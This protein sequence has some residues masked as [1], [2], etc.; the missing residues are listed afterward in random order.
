MKNI[1][2]QTYLEHFYKEDLSAFLQAK[3]EP[4]AIRINTL[5]SSPAQMAG[6]LKQWKVD[7][8]FTPF[9]KNGI[10][11]HEDSLPLSHTL[12][13]FKG[14]FQYQGL[15]SQIPALALNPL[16]GQRVLDMAAAPGSKS[17]QLAAL[18]ENKGLL[19]L[20]DAVRSRLQALNSN[21]QKAGAINQLITYLPAERFGN[22]FPNFFDKILLDA[23]CT[24]LGTLCNSAEV[25]SWWSLQKLDKLSSL[26]Q[27]LLISAYK[28]LKPG[29]ELVYSTCSIA[30]EENEMAVQ[31]L[32]D[33]YHLK[34]LPIDNIPGI[35]FLPGISRYGSRKLHPD[36]NLT[37]RVAP[38]IHNMEG[39]F[40][41]R[42]QKTEE[43]KTSGLI[44]GATLRE[45]L[46][47]DDAAVSSSL[48]SI[49]DYWEIEQKIWQDYRFI[50]TKNRIWIV[51]KFIESLPEEGFTSAGLLL[52]EKKLNSWKL[53]NQSVQF[54]GNRIQQRRISLDV[55]D[56]KKLFAEGKIKNTNLETGYHILEREGEPL[57]SIYADKEYLR[58]R[59]P[60]RFRLVL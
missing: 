47:A 35:D 29:G 10:I 41:A 60:H 19:I 42:L 13:F 57:A 54:L 30:P 43:Y 25:A 12:E 46:S 7:F 17:T 53:F 28:A 27:V 55:N 23:P 24:A 1:E 11:L 31:K 44:P 34:I 21:V 3:A 18:M 16:P 6:R 33:K 15:S 2:L 39:F 58:L 52:A 22:L 8:D 56:L 5:K 45:T 40:I 9:H 37:L 51:N 20:N 36:M 26:Q 49:S 50:P 48:K 32:I 38:H 59:L 14:F 4:K